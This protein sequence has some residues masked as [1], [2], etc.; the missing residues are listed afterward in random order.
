MSNEKVK[1]QVDAD[2]LRQVLQ[3]LIGG[4]VAIREIMATRNLPG[5]MGDRNPINILVADFNAYAEST[6]TKTEGDSD[7]S[8]QR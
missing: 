4:G 8:S 1:I 5:K 7:E 2:A 3:A 6:R